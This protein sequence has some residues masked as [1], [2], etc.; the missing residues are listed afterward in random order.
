MTWSDR[1]SADRYDRRRDRSEPRRPRRDER[2]RRR[3]TERGLRRDTLL[4]PRGRGPRGDLAVG[5]GI[6][7]GGT[8][9]GADRE[10]SETGGIAV[11]RTRTGAD[12][13][14]VAETRV[15]VVVAI[16]LMGGDGG[17]RGESTG[18]GPAVTAAEGEREEG[19][20]D[21][22]GQQTEEERAEGAQGPLPVLFAGPPE[23]PRSP[24][25]SL[26]AGAAV[27]V[28]GAAAVEPETAQRPPAPP[29]LRLPVDGA[30]ATLAAGVIARVAA[31][32]VT[33]AVGAADPRRRARAL[34]RHRPADLLA[35]EALDR[36]E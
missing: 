20:V 24:S 26:A 7:V 22:E 31:G 27:A 34:C 18:R 36:S 19:E 2:R 33:V 9:N 6:F 29:V 14:C 4:R 3:I 25:D 21:L 12:G 17:V 28:A 23:V 13:R 16:A 1:K 8:G 30:D 5:N 35:L 11:E 15:A 10:P 32:A